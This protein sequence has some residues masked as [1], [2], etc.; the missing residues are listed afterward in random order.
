MK[1]FL[2]TPSVLVATFVMNLGFICCGGLWS[3]LS[4]DHV[5]A[6]KG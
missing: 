3:A 1:A 2:K 6:V 4:G 5:P